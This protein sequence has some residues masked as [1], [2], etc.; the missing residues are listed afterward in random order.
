MEISRR[1]K[2]KKIR[3]AGARN[4]ELNRQA[5]ASREIFSHLNPAAHLL[6]QHYSQHG[7]VNNAAKLS[8]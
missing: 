1:I 7:A 3:P 5:P 4:E 2:I 6:C 8:G